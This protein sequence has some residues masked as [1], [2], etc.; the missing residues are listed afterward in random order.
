MDV[1]V[2]NVVARAREDGVRFVRF[3]Y[4][5]PSGVIR[6]KNV[7]DDRLTGRMREPGGV[8]LLTSS[9]D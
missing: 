6:G 9:S 5:D 2:D 4:C 1:T 8:I 3:L 7:H